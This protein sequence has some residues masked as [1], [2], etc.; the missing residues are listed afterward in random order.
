[1]LE[2]KK[3]KKCN[4]SYRCHLCSKTKG[5]N[6]TDRMGAV[7]AINKTRNMT[8]RTG[9]AYVGRQ[10]ERTRQIIWVLSRPKIKHKT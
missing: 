3:K 1:M 10:N 5:K 7:Y 9:V 8:D 2:D 4:E 6:A